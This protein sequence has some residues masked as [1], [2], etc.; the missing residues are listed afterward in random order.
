M[1]EKSPLITL[2]RY[3]HVLFDNAY[4]YEQRNTRNKVGFLNVKYFCKKWK[5]S[6]FDNLRWT[7]SFVYIKTGYYIAQ[8]LVLNLIVNFKPLLKNSC[9][10]N[11]S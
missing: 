1:K 6:F 7:L 4:F 2:I 10:K 8:V 11:D 3:K 5:V 9:K